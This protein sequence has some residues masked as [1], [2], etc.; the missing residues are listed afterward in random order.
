[1]WNGCFFERSDLLTNQLTLDLCHYPDDCP[2]IP[3]NVDM[4]TMHDPCSSDTGEGDECT[5][6]ASEPSGIP[7]GF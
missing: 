5:D 3:L 7:Q 2:T 4:Q 1:M 6:P